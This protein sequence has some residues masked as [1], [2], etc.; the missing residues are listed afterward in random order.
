MYVT[1]T[2]PSQGIVSLGLNVMMV[3]ARRSQMTNVTAT[4]TV[5]MEAM[6]KDVVNILYIRHSIQYLMHT[7]FSIM[8]HDI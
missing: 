7:H 6:K 1:M 4:K 5:M 3:N 8:S 2:T